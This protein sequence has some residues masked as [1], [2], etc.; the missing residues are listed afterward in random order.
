MDVDTL[1][2]KFEFEP[3]AQVFAFFD[4]TLNHFASSRSYDHTAY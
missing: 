4:T 1:K 2:F 3:R